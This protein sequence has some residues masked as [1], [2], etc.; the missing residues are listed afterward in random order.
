M[1]S[2]AHRLGAQDEQSVRALYEDLQVAETYIRQRFGHPWGRLLHKKQVAEIN[3][4]IQ[5]TRP[6]TVLEI[7]P[8]PARLATELT[9]VSHGVMLDNSAAML[10]LAKRRL[11][12]AGRGHLWQVKQGN[13][14]E[15]QQLDQQ[16]NFVFTFRFIRHFRLDERARLYGAIEACLRPEGL[17]MFDVVNKAI[18]DQ[19]DARN[20]RKPDDELDVYDETYGPDS[21]RREIEQY[22]FKILY[23]TPVLNHFLIQ[24]WIS[25]RLGQRLTSVSSAFIH[26]I[27]CVRSHQPLEWIALCQKVD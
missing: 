15:L 2:T 25:Q 23:L 19:V 20:P 14:F 4:V 12:D 6:E 11:Q 16:F 26:S 1:A 24:S 21:F 10:S 3:K 5:K 27:E 8:G 13:A 18:R 17:L 9:G 22:G 7:A